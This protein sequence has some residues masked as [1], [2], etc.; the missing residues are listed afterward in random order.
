MVKL[1][2]LSGWGNHHDRPIAGSE[3]LCVCCLTSLAVVVAPVTGKASNLSNLSKLT[4]LTPPFFPRASGVNLS[5]MD[6]LKP[7]D[8]NHRHDQRL[9]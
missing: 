3:W 2:K 9:R 7:G 1:V 8:R 5:S 6:T 4:N